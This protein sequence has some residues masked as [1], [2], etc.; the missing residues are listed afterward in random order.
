LQS[1]LATELNGEKAAGIDFDDD[2][3]DDD[4]LDIVGD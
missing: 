4:L 1:P 3:D 2:D